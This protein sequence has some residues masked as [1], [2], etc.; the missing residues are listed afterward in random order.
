MARTSQ[1]QADS[2]TTTVGHVLVRPDGLTVLALPSNTLGMAKLRVFREVEQAGW[3]VSLETLFERVGD[4]DHIGLIA[5][6][7]N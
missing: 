4:E 5:P 6:S 1:E 2:P 3:I 7:S